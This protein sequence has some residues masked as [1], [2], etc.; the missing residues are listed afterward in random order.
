MRADAGHL[1]A[2]ASLHGVGPSRLRLILQTWEP[3]EAW[4]RDRAGT[5]TREPALA[6]ALGSKA[7]E[8]T[9]AW[10]TQAAALDPEALAARSVA[11]GLRLLTADD[12]AFPAS[13]RG[14]LEPP[15][16]LWALGDLDAVRRPAV[17]VVGTRNCTRYGHDVARAAGREL[18][19]AGVPVVSGLALGIDAAAHRGALEEQRAERDELA[20]VPVDRAVAAHVEALLEQLLQLGVH[21][22]AVGRARGLAEARLDASV[23]A[24]RHALPFSS[25][26][27]WRPPER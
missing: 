14:D 21:R 22:E 18:A 17:G 1:T 11:L 3:A 19:E 15:V 12:D 13:L 7:R 2:L 16:L 10:R 4:A 9:V 25:P 24:A 26:W 8:L 20:E 23:P 5:A 6:E 27:R